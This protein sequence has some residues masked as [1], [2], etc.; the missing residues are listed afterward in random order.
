MTP[1]ETREALRRLQEAVAF[2]NFMKKLFGREWES[3]R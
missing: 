2:R 1:A 3:Q